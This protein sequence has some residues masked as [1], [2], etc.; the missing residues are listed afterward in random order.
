MSP[1]VPPDRFSSAFLDWLRIMDQTPCRFH[2]EGSAVDVSSRRAQ[3]FLAEA[4]NKIIYP[5]TDVDQELR[6]AIASRYGADPEAIVIAPN[7]S[8][9]LH[10]VCRALLDS[11]HG[12]QGDGALVEHPVYDPF[13]VTPRWHTDNVATFSRDLIDQPERL[14]RKLEEFDR[15]RLM[16]LSDL[17]NPTSRQLGDEDFVTLADLARKHQLTVVIDEVFR[18]LAPPFDKFPIPAGTRDPHFI[19]LNSFSKSYGWSDL[20]KCGWIIAAPSLVERLRR[21]AESLYN[22]LSFIDLRLGVLALADLE[23]HRA[24]S[25][26][27]TA[28]NRERVRMHLDPL[29]EEGILRCE[30]APY[31]ST[32]FPS[33]ADADQA[34][35]A[36]SALE[37]AGVRVAPGRFFGDARSFR[38][39]YGGD[40]RQLA[41]ALNVLTEVLTLTLRARP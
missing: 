31:G 24:E 18:D 3:A 5:I 16:I 33:L 7:A 39:G 11:S 38:L 21:T 10:V 23:S 17:H 22:M 13:L 14:A 29:I 15:P 41:D 27:H 25:L 8:T 26:Q 20:F 35:R 37:A 34:N 36:I 30:L 19:S 6:T 2:L 32:C 9:A 28:A 4:R 1:L 12:V 40:A